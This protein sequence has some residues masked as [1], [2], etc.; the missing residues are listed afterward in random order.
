MFDQDPRVVFDLGR[1]V[2]RRDEPSGR[3][4]YIV[5]VILNEPYLALVRWRGAE[6]TFEPLD[7]LVEASPQLV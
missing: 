1:P 6:A 7:N 3:L 5:A 2:R 4:G